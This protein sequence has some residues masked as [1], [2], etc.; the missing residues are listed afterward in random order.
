M[1]RRSVLLMLS[2]ALLLGSCRENRVPNGVISEA[3]DEMKL[4]NLA[5][6]PAD[7]A[8]HL[9]RAIAAFDRVLTEF[10]QSRPARFLREQ[11]R[12]NGVTLDELKARRA[13]LEGS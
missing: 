6:T 13:A 12:F 5:A 11:G 3:V 7:K 9:D 1:V 10:P 8:R 4:A 2:S